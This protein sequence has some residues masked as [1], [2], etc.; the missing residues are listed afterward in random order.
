METLWFI[1]VAFML[2]MYV[3]FDGFDLGAGIIHLFAAKN[4]TERRTILNAIGPVWD[5]NEVWLIAAA[6]SLYLAFPRLYAASFSGFYLPLMLLLWLLILRA[7]GIEFRH[8]VQNPLWKSFWDVIFSFASI[9]LSVFFGAALGNVVRGVPLN[10][11]GTFFEPL[12]TTFT[13]V[14][15]AGVLDW[16]TV[17]FGL[18]SFFTLATHGANFIALKTEGELQSRARFIA[19]K[20]WW[21]STV[22]SIL[23]F[24]STWFI[25]PQ[26]W[27]N[28][29]NHLWGF[30]FPAVGILGLGASLY[31]NKASQ[32]KQAF[33]FFSLFIG[34]MFGSTAFGMYPNV[35]P[36]STDPALNLTIYNSAAQQYGLTVALAWWILGAALA[37]AYFIYIYRSFRGKVV[38][39]PDGAGY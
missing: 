29:A 26:I 8:Q 36:A 34:G 38:L 3:V 4:E 2:T 27:E 10:R 24:A 17:A 12:W 14:P 37:A 15:E 28:Y 31:Y 20:T 16:F 5:G 23:V 33:L 30:V 13:V 6:G 9:L 39:P 32:D 19:G 22:G 18:V 1:I 11:E 7:L 35:L 25:R 21:G